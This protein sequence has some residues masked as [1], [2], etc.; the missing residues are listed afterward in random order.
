[1]IAERRSQSKEIL[2]AWLKADPHRSAAP[3]SDSV[4]HLFNFGIGGADV[5]QQ[6]N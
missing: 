2:S 4:V 5:A 6:A 3:A 1:M